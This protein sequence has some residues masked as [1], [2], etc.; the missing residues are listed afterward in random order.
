M[1]ELFSSRPT[2]ENIFTPSAE[3]TDGLEAA[4]YAFA[5]QLEMSA[6]DLE[7]QTTPD[8]HR[9]QGLEIPF[10]REGTHPLNAWLCTYRDG[11]ISATLSV[12]NKDGARQPF[13]TISRD[14]DSA[15][16]TMDN[17]RTSDAYLLDALDGE[18]PSTIIDN[19]TI[20]E[21]TSAGTDTRQ[22]VDRGDDI[23]IVTSDL[24][25]HAARSESAKSYIYYDISLDE[26]FVDTVRTSNEATLTIERVYR[27]GEEPILVITLNCLVPY[28]V[29]G[30][31][32]LINCAA[33]V[34][35]DGDLYL[36]TYYTDPQTNKSIDLS[37]ADSKELLYSMTQALAKLTAEKLSQA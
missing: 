21:M 31:D 7:L 19:F 17:Q 4:R 27:S 11:R 9:Q 1:S 3:T 29:N 18:W 22:P 36:E 26:S 33:G 2:P 13:S 15:L 34:D 24:I 25:S 23:R 32:V 28:I 16:W 6:F 37:V 30:E 10:G 20:R 5:R 14:P 35:V 12:A 8:T